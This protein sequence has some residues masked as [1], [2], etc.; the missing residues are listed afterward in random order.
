MSARALT[1]AF[2]CIVASVLLGACPVTPVEEES[3]Q[4]FEEDGIIGVDSQM[5]IADEADPAQVDF[6]TNDSSFITS[7]GYTLYS[8][9]DSNPRTF[10]EMDVSLTKLSGNA[11][12]GYG[13]ILNAFD[14]TE[15]GP[16]FLVLMINT[17]GEY[18]IGEV[19]DGE[20]SAM[21]PWSSSSKLGSGYNRPN[22][23]LIS[24]DSNL[25][26]YSLC[27]NG[28]QE[29]VFSDNQAPY[30]LYGQGGYVTVIS[31][32]DDFPQIPVHTRFRDNS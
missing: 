23:V 2:A 15:L 28:E 14:D 6:S 20:F 32:A 22:Q 8:L 12:A 31:P 3:Q 5:F 25:A 27:I 19:I 9:V 1:S 16:V 17:L 7:R 18:V 21:V 29:L 13:L 24:Y 4:A 10:T 30:H 11:S 26:Q